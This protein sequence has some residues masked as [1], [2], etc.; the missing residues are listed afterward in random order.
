MSQTVVILRYV[1]LG[2]YNFITHILTL[3]VIVP[4]ILNL[5]TLNRDEVISQMN[6]EFVRHLWLYLQHKSGNALVY[7][8]LVLLIGYFIVYMMTPPRPVYLL[9]YSLY[10]APQAQKV[11]FHRFRKLL[12]LFREFHESSIEFQAKI[13]SRSGIG[14]ESYGPDGLQRLPPATTL[15]LSREETEQVVF[16]ALDNLF[17]N[18]SSV[19]AED[20]GILVV[21]CSL[22]CPSPSISSM[23]VSKYKLRESIK[24][25]SLG[26]MGCS[27]GLVSIN[28]AQELLKVCPNTY[29]LVVSTE[30]LT[31]NFYFGNN[32]SMLVTNCLFRVGGAAILLSNKSIDKHRAKYKLVHVVR[33]HSGA[34]N[35]AYLCVQRDEDEVGGAGISLSKDLIAIAG[36][37]LKANITRLGLLVL[38]ISEQLVFIATL[39]AKKVFRTKIKA[40]VPDFKQVFDHFCIHAGGK[41]VIEGMEKNLQL[42][43]INVEASRMT[44]HRFGNTSSSSLWYE[45][46]YIEAKGRMREGHRIWQIAFGSGFKCNSAVWKALRN[47]TPS[48]KSPWEDCID[49]Y[50]VQVGP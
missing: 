42:L 25:F 37:S 43:P 29:A 8:T 34:D 2:L 14:E 36:L 30:N 13:L 17:A 32:K 16:G 45:L 33:T 49:K 3:C 28:V 50:P 26:G 47:V 38:P 23:I 18:N 27:A 9:D 15:A 31:Q 46:A 20:I 10:N 1:K 7:L 5:V 24:S 35:K 21:N 44:L 22:F 12:G 40:Y 41:A 48:P 19:K 4:L 6:L 11:G 39:L